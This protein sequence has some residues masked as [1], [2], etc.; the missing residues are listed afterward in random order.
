MT[1]VW[2]PGQNVKITAKVEDGTYQ[3]DGGY[4]EFYGNGLAVMATSDGE[5]NHKT[6]GSS[7]PS[8]WVGLDSIDG[9]GSRADT[10]NIVLTADWL[11]G[12][13]TLTAVYG[14]SKFEWQTGFDIDALTWDGVFS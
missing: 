8:D 7:H 4:G 1:A 5:L 12:D 9:P 13:S 3:Q 2:E 11:F 6:Q 10:T 14:F